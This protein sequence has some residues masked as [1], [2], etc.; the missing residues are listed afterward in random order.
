MTV[1]A[2]LAMVAG[3]IA[4]ILALML[5]VRLVAARLDISPELQRKIIHV[6]TG[7]YALTIPLM[8]QKTWPVF[9]LVAL[10][11]AT[12]MILRLPR[13]S[14]DGMSSVLHAVKRRSHG[15]IYLSLAIGFLFFRAQGQPVLYVLP[16]LVL[17]LSDAAAALVGSAYG[18]RLFL[19]A[20]GVKSLEGSIACFVVTW[21]V[22]MIALLLLADIPKINVV[23][24]S[25]LVAA[26]G[27]L[28]EA[29]SWRGLDNLFVPIG[30]HLLLATHLTSDPATLL[31]LTAFF[32][33]AIG[34]IL[35]AAPWLGLSA[36]AAR[37][38][39]VLVFLIS[40]YSTIA[41]ALLPLLAVAAHLVSRHFRPEESQY[42]D[43]DFLATAALVSLFWLFIGE[44]TNRST[45]D[46]YELTF[47]AAAAALLTVPLTGS[48][49][50]LAVPIAG[51]ITLIT[52]WIT[53][54][55]TADSLPSPALLTIGAPIVLAVLL[56]LAL[57]S[58]FD[59]LR[60]LKVFALALLAPLLLFT[61]REVSW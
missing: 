53:Q 30:V 17:T 47:A 36:H 60:S 1:G 28:I 52:A 12:M 46:L 7:L 31:L 58:F 41:T 9:L 38:V 34:G 20:D 35:A 8:F 29:D 19:I 61:L 57:P 39:I 42:P 15:E 55:D 2:N 16:I 23:M 49:H 11:I 45:V 24:L 5:L 13:F 4:L 6:V 37:V 56:A 10:S 14:G 51:A 54:S 32:V 18:R 26:F 59:R 48:W 27:T 21:L 44:Q 22:A 40:T 3:S 43:L 50:L 25:F 33:A